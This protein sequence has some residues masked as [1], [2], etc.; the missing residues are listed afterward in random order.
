VLPNSAGTL[1][2]ALNTTLPSDTSPEEVTPSRLLKISPVQKI[3]NKYSISEK[4]LFF[5][6]LKKLTVPRKS[7]R[8]KKEI[9]LKSGVKL[10]V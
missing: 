9:K 1:L 5:F 6:P 2:S 4:Q 8:M 10:K 3:P 7:E